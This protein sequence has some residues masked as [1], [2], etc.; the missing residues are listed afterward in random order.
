MKGNLEHFDKNIVKVF[1]PYYCNKQKRYFV[2]YIFADG[3]KRF[4]QYAKY[5]MEQ[6]LG[7]IL[8]KDEIVDHIDRDRE[9]NSLDNLRIVTISKSSKEDVKRVKQIEIT[10]VLC[11][12][13]VFKSARNLNHNA[14]L[15]KAGPFC[16]RKCSGKYGVL[17][18]NNKMEKL[19]TQPQVPVSEREYFHLDKT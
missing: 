12:E 8:T 4:L 2:Q 13:K 1:G 18:Q 11:K 5:L 15:G 10:C 7:R 6:N 3:K 19:K 14:N 16:S 17:I 9:N